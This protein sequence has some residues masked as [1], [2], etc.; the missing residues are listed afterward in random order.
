MVSLT[1]SPTNLHGYKCPLFIGLNYHITEF[2]TMP[3]NYYSTFLEYSA[4]SLLF[5]GQSCHTVS[6]QWA[7]TS[8]RPTVA[9]LRPKGLAPRRR[10]SP[11][12]RAAPLAGLRRAVGDALCA[13]LAFAFRGALLPR[14]V[15][16]GPGGDIT[17][18]FPPGHWPRSLRHQ[19]RAVALAGPRRSGRRHHQLVFA[20]PLASEPP[21][22]VARCCLGRSLPVQVETSSIGLRPAAQEPC[23]RACAH[24]ERPRLSTCAH[25]G[26]IVRL[27]SLEIRLPPPV[28]PETPA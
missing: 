13:P 28:I 5:A 3:L 25:L 1:C 19:W 26:K 23:W 2:I 8:G 24:R 14:R 7:S 4:A 16:A 22:S 20:R 21:P 9:G 27:V 18:W 6:K 15:P 10:P 11:P 12:R 17:S